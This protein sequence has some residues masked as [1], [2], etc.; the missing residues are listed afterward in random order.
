MNA[1]RIQKHESFVQLDLRGGDLPELLASC[2]EF[3]V[4]CLTARVRCALV[5]GGDED[6]ERRLAV[7]D[8]L[9]MIRAV[10]MPRDFRLA[11]VPGTPRMRAVYQKSEAELRGAGVDARFFESE[12]LAVQWFGDELL[13]EARAL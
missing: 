7:R 12:S 5:Q 9:K 3:A 6:T 13:L 2:T 10:G 4:L 8:L 11:L 1:H